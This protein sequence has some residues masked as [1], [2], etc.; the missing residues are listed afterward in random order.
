MCC[1]Q[2]W[3]ASG[4]SWC[5]NCWPHM[6]LSEHRVPVDLVE[7]CLMKMPCL[8][9][10]LYARFSDPYCLCSELLSYES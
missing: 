1:G 6:G 8:R 10:V 9:V 4:V 7:H 5:P 3:P 2:Q